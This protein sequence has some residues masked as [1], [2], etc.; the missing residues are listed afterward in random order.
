M[1]FPGITAKALLVMG[2]ELN[3][4]F[5]ITFDGSDSM[6]PTIK[7]PRN[8]YLE[9]AVHALIKNE[10]FIFGGL[11]DARKVR[12][13]YNLKVNELRLRNWTDANGK[14]NRQD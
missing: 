9:W 8:N 7:A 12:K 1:Y 5:S 2:R 6:T 4:A 3:R 11:P 10:L 13:L 14:S